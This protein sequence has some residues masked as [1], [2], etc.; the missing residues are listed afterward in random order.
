MSITYR[1]SPS[2]TL[3]RSTFGSPEAYPKEGVRSIQKVLSLLGAAL[4]QTLA[5]IPFSGGNRVELS[6]L[7]GS[8]LRSGPRSFSAFFS[9]WLSSRIR[10]P[11]SVA[12][13]IA[14]CSY[15]LLRSLSHRA[16]S[17]R[18]TAKPSDA[19]SHALMAVY[20]SHERQCG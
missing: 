15:Q 14:S 18:P 12:D 2:S 8:C 6:H 9:R 20:R 4:A 7:I 17:Q 5:D 10:M 11:S 13:R 16:H 1:T 3:P 19:S